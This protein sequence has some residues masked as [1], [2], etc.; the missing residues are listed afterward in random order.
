MSKNKKYFIL[1]NNINERSII[2]TCEKEKEE[3]RKELNEL[4]KKEY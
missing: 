4:Y 3:K 1:N 2:N